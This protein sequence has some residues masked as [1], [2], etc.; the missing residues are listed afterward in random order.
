MQENNSKSNIEYIKFHECPKTEPILIGT[1]KRLSILKKIVNKISC[2]E[3]LEELADEYLVIKNKYLSENQIQKLEIK[4]QCSNSMVT[5]NE[6]NEISKNILKYKNIY[7]DVLVK[8]FQS[9]SNIL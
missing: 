8:E 9:L 7:I 4:T 5:S 3:N 2:N 6:I 1:S